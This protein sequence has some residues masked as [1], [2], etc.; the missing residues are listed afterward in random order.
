MTIIENV[1]QTYNPEIKL[2]IILFLQINIKLVRLL[3]RRD[4]RKKIIVKKAWLVNGAIRCTWGCVHVCMQFRDMGHNHDQQ[5]DRPTHWWTDRLKR[6]DKRTHKP[7]NW[8]TNELIDQPNQW[9]D[10]GIKRWWTSGWTY[11]RTL[12][13]EGTDLKRSLLAWGGKKRWKWNIKKWTYDL[14][15]ADNDISDKGTDQLT[16]FLWMLGL[17]KKSEMI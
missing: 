9:M 13:D 11:W 10:K 16:T 5:S 4:L 14:D 6:M 12:S 7:T 17:S 8:W 2:E 15:Q 1:W 3:R